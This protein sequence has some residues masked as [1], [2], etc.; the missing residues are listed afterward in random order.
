MPDESRKPTV[1]EIGARFGSLIVAGGA[2]RKEGSRLTTHRC[3]CDCGGSIDVLPC[4]LRSGHNRSCGCKS[5]TLPANSQVHKVCPGTRFERLVVTG[6][7]EREECLGGYGKRLKTPCKCDC[8]KELRVWATALISGNTRSCGCLQADRTGVSGRTH[9]ESKT[10]LHVVWCG[11]KARC[12]NPTHASYENYGGRGIAVSPEWESDYLAF[13]AWSLANG[14][15]K[16]L[17]LDRIDNDGPYSSCNCRWTTYAV[18]GRNKRSNVKV[19]AF[20][21]TKTLT[22]WHQDARCT[23]KR[24]GILHRIGAGFSPEDAITKP[25][26]TRSHNRIIS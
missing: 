6:E 4:R 7:S 15:R 26:Y 1:L 17:T 14:Y 11:M 18:Q 9:G 5:P 10:P 16:G 19:T 24:G 12:R 2:E 8:G 22:E 23:V 20:G 3:E 13:K 25:P 21:E